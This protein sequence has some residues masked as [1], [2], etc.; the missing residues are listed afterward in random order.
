[1]LA[2][3]IKPAGKGQFDYTVHGSTVQGRSRHPLLDACRQLKS[4]GVDPATLVALFHG[5]ASN[6]WTVR[7][8]VGKGAELMVG[9]PPSG[10][11]PLFVKYSKHPRAP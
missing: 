6:Q 3:R 2:I 4:M 8:T 9:D 11:G 5:E 10:G 1:M 7:T